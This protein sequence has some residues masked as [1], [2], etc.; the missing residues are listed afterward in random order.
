MKLSTYYTNLPAYLEYGW[1][2]APNAAGQS[3]SANTITTLTLNTE[4]VD[5]GGYGSISLNPPNQVTLAAG[6]YYFEASTAIR[7]ATYN[8]VA[9]A[10]LA[11]YNVTDSAYVTRGG[12]AS[13]T[14]GVSYGARGMINGQFTISGSKAFDLRILCPV[15]VSVDN[16]T[17]N[18]DLSTLTTA[19]ADQRTT[20]KLWKVA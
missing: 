13:F 19:S 11:F 9:S 14:G 2:C 16:G 1:V 18:L 6:T 15:A 20:L 7:H 10:L 5:A 3:I 8:A 12:L 4:V 17:Y